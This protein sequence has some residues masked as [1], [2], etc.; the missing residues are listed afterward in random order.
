MD[1]SKLEKGATL[2]LKDITLPKDVE[3]VLRGLAEEDVVLVSVVMPAAEE[4]EAGAGEA[5]AEDE[6]K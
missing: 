4:P 5:A 6:K 2:T 3:P 1:L